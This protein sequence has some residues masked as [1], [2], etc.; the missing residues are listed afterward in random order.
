MYKA[1]IGTI[2]TQKQA[3]KIV[4]ELEVAGFA[5]VDISVLFPQMNDTVGFA[6]SMETKLPEAAAIGAVSVA[7]AGLWL[8]GGLGLL[9]GLGAIVIPGIGAFLAVGP[10]LSML[11]GAVVG[12]TVGATVGT[13]TGVLVSLGIPEQQARH[14]EGRVTGGR[15]LLSVHSEDRQ[16]QWIAAGILRRLGAEDISAAEESLEPVRAPAATATPT[17]P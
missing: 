15:I 6:T 17:S 2:S 7:S 13:I 10:L 8:G 3:E 9:A 14:Y 1:V 16:R 5:P 11:S 4:N 12:A